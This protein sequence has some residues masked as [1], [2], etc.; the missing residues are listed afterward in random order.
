MPH[1]DDCREDNERLRDAL[2]HVELLLKEH[3]CVVRYDRPADRDLVID[4]ALG[5]ISKALAD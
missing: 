5:A 3:R 2:I 4:T 1:C